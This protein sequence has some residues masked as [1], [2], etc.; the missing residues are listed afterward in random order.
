MY[1]V[2]PPLGITG[3]DAICLF[4][5]L[6]E[7]H[8]CREMEHRIPKPWHQLPWTPLQKSKKECNM[9]HGSLIDH[10]P[11]ISKILYDLYMACL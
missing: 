9:A 5:E 6:C 1:L 3:P 4:V 2:L 8:H 7:G 11:E 10:L